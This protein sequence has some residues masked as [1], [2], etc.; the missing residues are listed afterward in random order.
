MLPSVYPTGHIPENTEKLLLNA[1][2]EK[3]NSANSKLPPS[4]QLGVILQEHV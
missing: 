2:L 3:Q 1:R 4:T